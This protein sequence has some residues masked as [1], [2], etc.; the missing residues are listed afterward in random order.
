MATFAKF[1]RLAHYLH[2]FDQASH[3]CLKNGL[4]RM[5]ASLAIPVT[6]FWRIWQIFKVGYFMYKKRYF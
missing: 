2:E 6:A 5:L 3:I 4:W 1:A